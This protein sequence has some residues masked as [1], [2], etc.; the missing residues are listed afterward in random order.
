MHFLTRYHQGW[1]RWGQVQENTAVCY[2]HLQKSSQIGKPNV[3][4]TLF[5]LRVMKTPG[6]WG[7][8]VESITTG[9]VGLEFGDQTDGGC[10]KVCPQKPIDRFWCWNQW[11]MAVPKHIGYL[12][13]PAQVSVSSCLKWWWFYLTGLLQ[14]I[15]EIYMHKEAGPWEHV[16]FPTSPSFPHPL[17]MH[18]CT[19]P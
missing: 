16:A 14:E 15:N 5:V 13:H 1:K 4:G 3:Q 8:S 2:R 17:P 12:Y 9:I 6:I 18:S 19:T 7:P 11:E 10:E